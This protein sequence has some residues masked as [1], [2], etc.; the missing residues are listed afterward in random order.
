M[1]SSDVVQAFRDAATLASDSEENVNTILRSLAGESSG[2]EM[3]MRRTQLRFL[4][5]NL[6]EFAGLA[7]ILANEFQQ[8]SKLERTH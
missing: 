6:R 3:V 2:E 7:Q 1:G 5:Q 8:L 4:Q